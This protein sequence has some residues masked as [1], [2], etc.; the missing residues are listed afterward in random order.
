MVKARFKYGWQEHERYVCSLLSLD[1]TNCS[2]N[3]FYDPGDGVD[4]SH[5]TQNDFALIIDAKC[6]TKKSFSLNSEF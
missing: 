4:R 6:T 3:K 5:Y 2:G 1:L